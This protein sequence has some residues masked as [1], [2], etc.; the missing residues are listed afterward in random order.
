MKYQ[1]GF[2]MHLI[3]DRGLV[4]LALA[5]TI[6]SIFSSCFSDMRVK[7]SLWRRVTE[8]SESLLAPLARLVRP[9]SNHNA[10]MNNV[11]GCFPRGHIGKNTNALDSQTKRVGKR[12]GFAFDRSRESNC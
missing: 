3:M 11:L 6:T 9:S 12:C 4:A 10:H 5:F 1:R 8:A 2:H 7:R